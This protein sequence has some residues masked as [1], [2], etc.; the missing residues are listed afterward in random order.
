ML[1]ALV[2]ACM[3]S[4]CS[5]PADTSYYA[6]DTPKG[7]M[8]VRLYDETPLH[9][10]NFKKLAEEGFYDGTL[11]HRVI[12]G[13]MIQGGDPNSKND[14]PGDDGMGG[15]EYRIPAEI[16]PGLFH[17]KGALAAARD[18]NPERQSSGSQFYL[19]QGQVLP[20]SVLTDLE[21]RMK[22]QLGAEFGISP[23]AR[24]AYETIGGAPWLDGQYTV[25]GELVEGMAVLD[26]L[27]VTPTPRGS[28][29]PAPPQLADRPLENLPMTVTPLP[30]YGK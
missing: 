25:F 16:L 20:D 11:F 4:G 15:P 24:Q 9:R 13:F 3:L 14:D 27:A 23:E 12:R 19:V 30:N 18:N 7:R 29:T 10:D 22:A 21:G 26:S 2:F 5:A 6:I 17:K 8:V 1:S 28:G